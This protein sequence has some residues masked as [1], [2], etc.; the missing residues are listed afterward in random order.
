LTF[1]VSVRNRESYL[2]S[3]EEAEERKRKPR[4]DDMSY[5]LSNGLNLINPEA[6]ESS[7]KADDLLKTL[8]N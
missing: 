3:I 7:R 1:T 8:Y 5:R 2:E 6:M 4:F